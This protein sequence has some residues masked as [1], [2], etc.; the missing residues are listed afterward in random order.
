MLKINERRWLM[1]DDD[2]D[3]DDVLPIAFF[4]WAVMLCMMAFFVGSAIGW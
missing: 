3:Y 4:C 1:Y 2:D